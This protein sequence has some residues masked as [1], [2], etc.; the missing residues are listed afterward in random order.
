VTVRDRASNSAAAQTFIDV[1]TEGPT[2][3]ITSL[4]NDSTL[5]EIP[6]SLYGWAWDRN[7]V[8]DTLWV[9]FPGRTS[10]VLNPSGT[11]RSDT[12]FFSSVLRDSILEEGSHLVRFKAHDKLGQERIKGFNITWDS[13][14]PP[15]PVLEKLPATSHAPE[16]LLQGTAE[17]DFT[18]VM[19]IYRNGAAIDTLQPEI[20]GEW[21]RLVAL[22]PGL[23]RIHAVMADEAGNTS[24]PSNTVEVTFDPAGGLYIAQPFRPGDAF[25]VNLAEPARYVTLRVYDMGGHLVRVLDERYGGDFVSIAWDGLNGD[26]EKAKKGPLVAVALVERSDGAKDTLRGIFLFEP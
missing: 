5:S 6:D 8:T 7:G 1:D 26:G 16:I 22:E 19:R 21:P 15:A 25:Q 9:E 12:L 2:I 11:M 3:T 24:A 17:G 4:A 18:D 10:F 14:A 20:T 23:N 13:T